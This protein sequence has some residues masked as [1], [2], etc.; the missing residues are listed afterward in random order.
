LA[1]SLAAVK[2]NETSNFGHK[3]GKMRVYDIL[4]DLDQFEFYSYDP[5]SKKFFKDEDIIV[6]IRL[7]NFTYS[8]ITGGRST[9]VHNILYNLVFSIKQNF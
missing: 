9:S 7:E 6:P 1:A 4:T 3:F 8:M 2:M 5:I